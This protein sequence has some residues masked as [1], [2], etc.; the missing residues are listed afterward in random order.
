MSLH[1]TIQ[2]LYRSGYQ[3]LLSLGFSTPELDAKLLICH[4]AQISET[5]FI[6]QQNDTVS[7]EI[8][9]T[10]ASFLKRREAYEPIAYILEKKEFYGHQ[11]SVCTDVLIPRPETELLVDTIS[12][13]FQSRLI[14]TDIHGIDLGT[15]SGCISISLLL[16]NPS[17]IM[18]A[19]DLSAS[20]L[21]TAQT[22]ALY[23][24]VSD[25]LSLEMISMKDI[26]FSKKYHFI[27]SNPPYINEEE[28]KTL[29]EEVRLY[30]PYLALSGGKDG[31]E[32]YYHIAEFARNCLLSS[33]IVAVEIGHNQAQAVSEIFRSSGFIDISVQKDLAQNDRVIFAIK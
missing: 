31:L 29:Q 17:M 19:V 10:F 21:K 25:R 9:K 7:D 14:Y 15:G 5:Q 2:K 16:E 12:N 22:N 20:A 18:T 26:H 27:V 30:E 23:H 1:Y 3:R 24:Q 13:F 6:I 28:M 33:G 32:Y 11:F 4:A 8:E